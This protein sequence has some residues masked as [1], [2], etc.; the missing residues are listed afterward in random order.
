MG[1]KR[2]TVPQDY[3]PG[4]MQQ[5][6]ARTGVAQALQMR[7]AAL[8]DDLG[9]SDALSYQQRSLVER[10]LWLEYWLQ[11][12][13]I[14]L[15]TGADFDAGKW[16]QACNALQGIYSKLG[17]QRVAHDVNLGTFLQNKGAGK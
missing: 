2:K 5:L 15:A 8:T 1:S 12:Q 16:T 17:L 9:G 10:A 11:Q 3:T 4:F 7:F 6:D 14:Q 13:E